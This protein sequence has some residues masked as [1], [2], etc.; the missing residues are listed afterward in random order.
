MKKIIRKS[1]GALMLAI[2]VGASPWFGPGCMNQR[3]EAA[4]LGVAAAI[5]AIIMTGLWLLT[6]DRG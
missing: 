6:T 2:P 1:I 3:P 4:I 5:T